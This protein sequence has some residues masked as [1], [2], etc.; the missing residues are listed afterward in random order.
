M[1]EALPEKVVGDL[2]G[3][4]DHADGPRN[5]VWWGNTGFMLIEGTAFAL[6]GGAY[7]YLS[8]QSGA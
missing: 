2:S 1:T 6:A 4:P 3:L 7:L 8:S 5:V